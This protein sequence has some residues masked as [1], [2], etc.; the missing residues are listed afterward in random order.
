MYGDYDFRRLSS[1]RPLI[2]S[3]SIIFRKVG[4]V[5]QHFIECVS[6]AAKILIETKTL[7]LLPE[8]LPTLFSIA[9]GFNAKVQSICLIVIGDFEVEEFMKYSRIITGLHVKIQ[10][11]EDLE[12]LNLSSDFYFPNIRGLSLLGETPIFKSLSGALKMNSSI[13]AVFLD[14]MSIGDEVHP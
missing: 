13:T 14:N 3:V 9:A 10:K 6:Q 11:L 8:E 5:S 2:E 12:F 4:Y 7:I 1:L